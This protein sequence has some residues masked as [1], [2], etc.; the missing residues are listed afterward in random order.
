MTPIKLLAWLPRQIKALR[1][2]VKRVIMA[3][4]R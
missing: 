3:L 1:V 4:G 2:M